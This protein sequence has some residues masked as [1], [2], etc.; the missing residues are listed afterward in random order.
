MLL[1]KSQ[2]KDGYGTTRGWLTLAILFVLLTTGTGAYSQDLGA[3]TGENTMKGIRGVAVLVEDVG[4]DAEGD[5][6]TRELIQT[7]VEL[8]L[9]KSGIA[10]YRNFGDL[11]KD[12]RW[13]VLDINVQL[14]KLR[15]SESYVYNV[16]VE[17]TQTV[18]LLDDN[19]TE[20]CGVATWSRSVL[21]IIPADRL[22]DIRKETVQDLIDDFVNT[23]LEQNQQTQ[24]PEADS[25]K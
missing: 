18:L 21:G 24:T 19:L 13:P 2:H 16:A 20:A 12:D 1:A 6:L 14:L 15:S 17:L 3:D 8:Q 25:G 9:R 5:G 22:R 4:K 10:I 23:Y 7:D 11:M